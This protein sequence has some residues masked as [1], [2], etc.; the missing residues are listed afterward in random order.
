VILGAVAGLMG[1]GLATLFSRLLL[2]RF[3]DAKFSFD[4][5]PNVAAVVLTALLAVAAGWLASLRILKARPLEVLRD[6]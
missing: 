1:G 2:T 3:L 6:E 5:L 4:V